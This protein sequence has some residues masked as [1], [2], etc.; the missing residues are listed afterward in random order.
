MRTVR[1]DCPL[2]KYFELT[3]YLHRFKE[4]EKP[5]FYGDRVQVTLRVEAEKVTELKSD[6]SMIPDL[7]ISQ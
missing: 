1:I 4:A 5:V 6:L 7:K 3:Y 2:A